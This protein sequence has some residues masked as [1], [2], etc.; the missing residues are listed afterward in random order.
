MTENQIMVFE[1]TDVEIIT[2]DNKE[3]LFELYSTGMALGYVRQNAA[4]TF[5]PRK[6]RIDKT[7]KNA[8]IK[9]CV[10]DGH[11]YL[12]EEMLYDFMLE[13]RTEK[14]KPFRKW[15]TSE[16]LPA[17]RKTGGYIEKD[18]EMYNYIKQREVELTELKTSISIL[19]NQVI[20]LS[21]VLNQKKINIWK[22]K[23]I[24]PGIA[25]L[26]QKYEI[27]ERSAYD[28]VYDR[29]SSH[30]G[31]DRS[32]AINEFCDK[33]KT[34]ICYVT[35]AIADYEPYRKYFMDC[36]YELLDSD[37]LKPVDEKANS[38]KV[39]YNE[40]FDSLIASLTKKNNDKTA[41]GI[42]S[43]GKVYKAMMTDSDWKLMMSQNH[44]Y[45]KKQLILNDGNLFDN[46]RSVALNMLGGAGM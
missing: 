30:Y 18:S 4:G 42:G 25:M 5:Y 6:D 10:H 24:K 9:P 23:F 33:Y 12:T 2:N 29:M 3:P 13:A 38:Q 32:C 35:D 16:V 40:E 43:L 17:I 41:C 31:F 19:Q 8:F 20:A 44:C 45:S 14:C 26:V 7:V 36:V 37:A 15:V 28:L 1:G 22:S 34:E 39:K 21:P 11:S 46:F 27:N